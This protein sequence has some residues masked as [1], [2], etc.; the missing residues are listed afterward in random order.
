[1][2]NMSY[3]MYGDS[4]RLRAGDKPEKYKSESLP[5]QQIAKV[6]RNV[7][8]VEDYKSRPISYNKVCKGIILANG[9]TAV[10]TD[11]LKSLGVTHLLN[12]AEEHVQVSPT[13]LAVVGIQY[14]GFHVD[15]LP[16]S[17][18]SRYFKCTTD[19]IN[20]AVSSGGLVVVN[21]YMGLSRSATCVLAYLMMKQDMTLTKALSVVR[22]SRAVRPNEGFLTQ[23]TELQL[24]L[25]SRAC[26][27]ATRG[28]AL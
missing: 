25:S 7:A 6:C 12:A 17:N 18:I 14:H 2:P 28:R 16:E 24:R 21:C 27:A 26:G 22:A 19:F 3:S 23:L 9:E 20:S 4:G 13:K 15:D 11:V 10:S 1:M 5:S 8:K